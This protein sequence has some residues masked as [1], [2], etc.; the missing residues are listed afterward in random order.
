MRHPPLHILLVEDDEIDAEQLLRAF[1]QHQITNPVT[2]VIDGVDALH[3]L[4]GEG[5]YPRLPRPY[6]IILD[7]NMPRMNGLEFL[8]ALRRD[9]ELKR[10][11]VFILT[12]SAR[13]EDIMAAYNEQIAGYLLK[14]KVNQEFLEFI[15]LLNL[16][17]VMVEL[18]R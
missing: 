4:R 8:Q 7:I 16:Y 10:S 18:P 6:I 5:G 12:T 15:K 1:R 13:D 11:V 3:A 2:R 9:A 17:H 14:T